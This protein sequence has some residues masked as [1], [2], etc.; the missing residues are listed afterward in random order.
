[1][2]KTGSR[3][4][5][6]VIKS[7]AVKKLSDGN[8]EQAIRLQYCRML[9][10][11]ISV[12]RG[13]GR[14]ERSHE[15]LR[16]LS[17][18]SDF[19]WPVHTMNLRRDCRTSHRGMIMS[20]SRLSGLGRKVELPN[21]RFSKFKRKRA[22]A[23]HG[24]RSDDR[25]ALLWLFRESWRYFTQWRLAKPHSRFLYGG[26]VRGAKILTP[27]WWVESPRL[28]ESL[29]MCSAEERASNYV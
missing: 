17:S 14:E 19:R 5:L 22:Q 7:S 23:D 13:R 6:K 29:R 9:S 4:L 10:F 2:R 8:T 3:P 26:H 27:P 24:P 16:L 28:L 18:K 15:A 21:G 25:M 20:R 1:M 12:M 11:L